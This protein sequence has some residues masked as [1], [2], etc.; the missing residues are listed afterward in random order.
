MNAN[1]ISWT[2]A[3]LDG[4][5]Q[6]RSSI[7]D[8]A[9]CVTLSHP[10]TDTYLRVLPVLFPFPDTMTEQVWARKAIATHEEQRCWLE[11]RQFC[12]DF[13]KTEPKAKSPGSKGPAT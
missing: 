2:A 7:V 8:F 13:H 9:A 10:D 3:A 11:L 5:G 4:W 6:Q 12:S 1:R